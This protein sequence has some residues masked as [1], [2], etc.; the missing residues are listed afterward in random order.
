[1]KKKLLFLLFSFL[2]FFLF[3]VKTA[4]AQIGCGGGFGPIANMFCSGSG[5]ANEI[6]GN[7]FNHVISSIVGFLTI[8]AGLWFF[9]TFILAGYAWISAGGDTEKTTAAWAKMYN[10]I[11]GLIIVVAAWV[12]VGLIGKLIG[13]DILNP[14]NAIQS[15]GF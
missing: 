14:G 5:N 8:M 4:S 6:A 15:L 9:I 7:A 2:S 11:I 12:I 10:A 1:M 13:V 3:P